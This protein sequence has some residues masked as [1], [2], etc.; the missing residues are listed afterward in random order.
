MATQEMPAMN[1]PIR[2]SSSRPDP[3][4]GASRKRLASHDLFGGAQEIL[5]EHTGQEYR[6]RITRQGKLILTK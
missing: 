3:G 5:I 4:V 6:L 1:P 2:E